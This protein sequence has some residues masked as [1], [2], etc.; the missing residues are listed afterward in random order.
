MTLLGARPRKWCIRRNPSACLSAELFPLR[1]ASLE[2]WL[3]EEDRA[4]SLLLK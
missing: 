2:S 3:E 1:R 4:G